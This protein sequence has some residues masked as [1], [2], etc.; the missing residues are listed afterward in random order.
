MPPGRAWGRTTVSSPAP[1]AAAR[2]R[3]AITNPFVWPYVRRGS[4][5]LLNDLACY[6]RDAG[7]AVTVFAMAPQDGQEVRD[8]IRYDLARE[9]SPGH[10][11]QLNSL[12]YFAWE[13]QKRLAREPF[14][15]VFCLNYFDA[16][17]ALRCRERWGLH[18]KVVFQNVGIPTRRYFRAVPLDWWFMRKVLRQADHCL[19]LS[20]FARECLQREF[21]VA[22]QVLPPP[23]VTEGFGAFSGEVSAPAHPVVLFVGDVDEPRKGAR[24]LCQAFARLKPRFPGMVLRLVGRVSDGTRAALLALPGVAAVR[25]SIEFSGVGQVGSLPAQYQGASVTVLPSVWEAFG[26]V[27]VESLAAGTPV[28]GARHGGITDVVD[29]ELVGALFD[30]GV[31]ALQ[32]DAVEALAAALLAVLERGKT[33]QVQAACR[34][35]AE[36]FSWRA[37]GPAYLRLVESLARPAGQGAA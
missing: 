1:A 37:Q 15:V 9:R 8:G 17:A 25:D 18:Y 30:P 19:V 23:V 35:R 10:R 32:S 12:H 14:D 21:G 33:P 7:H 2:L 5:R 24:V 34:D 4:E 31:F 26:L 22:A 3:V 28:V 16:Y 11:R 6:L 27:L 13:L 29:G 36:R 20:Q